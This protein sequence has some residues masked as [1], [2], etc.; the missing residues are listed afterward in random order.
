[1]IGH[2]SNDASTP[3]CLP[4]PLEALTHPALGPPPP[5]GNTQKKSTQS[6]FEGDSP[7]SRL[8][9]ARPC[10]LGWAPSHGTGPPRMPAAMTRPDTAIRSRRWPTAVVVPSC[11]VM[12]PLI[13]FQNPSS[14]APCARLARGR[15]VAS[16]RVSAHRLQS[17][18]DDERPPFAFSRRSANG[19]RRR[20]VFRSS[21]ALRHLTS[22]LS[23]TGKPAWQS[24]TTRTALS[25][26]PPGAT[27]WAISRRQPSSCSEA[28]LEASR[29]EHCFFY[30]ARQPALTCGWVDLARASHKILWWCA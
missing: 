8:A 11:R 26:R 18:P 30:P 27:L 23:R 9:L 15:Q 24:P 2:N 12:T 10:R 4:G 6:T 21:T 14:P 7:V 17:R 22:S 28:R 3:H 1:V 13:I 29:L 19:G 5:F 25:Q 16:S 20:L